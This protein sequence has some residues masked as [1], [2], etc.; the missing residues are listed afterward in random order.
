M[1]DDKDIRDQVL[2]T[3]Q[4][5]EGNSEWYERTKDF[6]IK[7]PATVSGMLGAL[8]HVA[9]PDEKDSLNYLKG[10]YRH[11][12][13]PMTGTIALDIGA[14]IGRVTEKVLL[15][16]FTKVDIHDQN[17][18]FLNKAWG[19]LSSYVKSGRLRNKFASPLQDFTPPEK[20]YD[21]IWIQWVIGYLP[22]MDLIRCLNRMKAALKPGK[23]RRD[24]SL[25]KSIMP[26]YF[27][28]LSPNDDSVDDDESEIP[29]KEMKKSKAKMQELKMRK[30]KSQTKKE[31]K[32]KYDDDEKCEDEIEEDEEDEENEEEEEEEEVKVGQKKD[33]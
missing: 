11:R 33:K 14:G 12:A 9:P 19:R 7:S 26:V 21:L 17:Q 24:E 18:N 13:T 6:W 28:L 23:A 32:R 5:I 16:C 22:S 30:E 2:S 3:E 8:P 31:R 1:E 10:M 20:E 4:M 25:P 15:K 29:M 27:F